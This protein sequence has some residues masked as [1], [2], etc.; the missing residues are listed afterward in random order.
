MADH[1]E[2]LAFHSRHIIQFTMIIVAGLQRTFFFLKQW[3][4][5][6]VSST[7]TSTFTK[8]LFVQPRGTCH[9]VIC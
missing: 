2:N 8:F 7:K 4:L 9:R 1:S 3:I 6:S 5:I